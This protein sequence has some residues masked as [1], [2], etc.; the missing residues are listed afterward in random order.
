MANYFARIEKYMSNAVDTVFAT[1]SK[2]ALL[3]NGAK[4]IDLDFKEAGYVKILSILMDGLSDYYR[5]GHIGVEGSESYS[6]DNSYNGVGTRDG[7]DR[8][9]VQGTWEIFK[10]EYDRGRQFLVDNMD[11][12]EMAGQIIAN[13]L[14]EFL[15]TKVVPE[16]DAVRFSKI[17]KKCNSGLGNL[18]KE[19]VGEDEI[20]SKFNTAFEWLTENE[21]PEEDQVIFVNPKIYTKIM[22]TS[23]LN[24]YIVQQDFTNEKGV[25]FKLPAYNGRP[26]VVVPTSRFFTNV[27][28]TSN[29]YV[30]T[31]DSKVINYIITS[32]KAIVPIVKLQKSKIWSPDTQDDFDGYKVNFRMYHDVIIPKNKIIG[33]FV[34]VSTSGLNDVSGKLG[35]NIEIDSV[36]STFA[37]NSYITKPSGLAG[38]LVF[39]ANNIANVGDTVGV[40]TSDSKAC[41]VVTLGEYYDVN[42]YTGASKPANATGYFYLIDSNN[43]VIAKSTNV[44]FVDYM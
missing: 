42:G 20:I 1:E 2:T 30:A 4:Y 18:V 37:V 43:K 9:N 35:V 32:K 22:S 16:V 34:S 15:R 28:T 38:T 17:A 14:S 8:G 6:H 13:L 44:N 27:K 11:N 40:G 31:E 3:E 24:K 23:E 10:L 21:V 26:I 41:K 12:E 29:G 5:V 19:T 7:Y 33:S 36:N 39:Q 25:S